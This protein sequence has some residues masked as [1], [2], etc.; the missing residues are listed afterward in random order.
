MLCWMFQHLHFPN[1]IWCYQSLLWINFWSN[2]WK[3]VAVS[4]RIDVAHPRI[5]FIPKMPLTVAVGHIIKQKSVY[6]IIKF[7]RYISQIEYWTNW[8]QPSQNLYQPKRGCRADKFNI[9]P[10][11]QFSAWSVFKSSDDLN[12]AARDIAHSILKLKLRLIALDK[13]ILD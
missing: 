2:W 6:F 13:L 7:I 1:H 9:P 12:R 11:R 4:E 5:P 3:G 10:K 8:I